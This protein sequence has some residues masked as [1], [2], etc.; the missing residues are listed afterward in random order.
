MTR[1]GEAAC[2]VYRCASPKLKTP[3]TPGACAGSMPVRPNPFRPN[4]WP[5]LLASLACQSLAVIAKGGLA[6]LQFLVFVRGPDF[7]NSGNL[8]QRRYQLRDG[9][10]SLDLHVESD[11]ALFR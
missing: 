4:P 10:F 2:F 6:L 8:T 9:P 7:T 1:R 11:C 3:G 5:K